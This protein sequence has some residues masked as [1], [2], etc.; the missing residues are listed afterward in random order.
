MARY[1][2]I[3]A[4]LALVLIVGAQ[5]AGYKDVT[6]CQCGCPRIGPAVCGRNSRGKFKRFGNKCELDCHNCLKK[7]FYA[8]TDLNN[9]HI[10]RTQVG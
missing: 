10:I 8:L 2:V 1:A 6:K 5:A 7:D 9:C 4:L 3:L